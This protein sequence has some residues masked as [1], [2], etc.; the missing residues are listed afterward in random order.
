MQMATTVPNDSVS[1]MNSLSGAVEKRYQDA[2]RVAQSIIFFGDV[3]KGGGAIGGIV[4]AIGFIVA[5]GHET[6]KVVPI[7][8][9]VGVLVAGAGWATGTI[10]AAIGQMMQSVVDTAVNTS[11]LL[12]AFH[13]AKLLGLQPD[14]E[15]SALPSTGQSQAE[16]YSRDSAEWKN[17]SEQYSRM[18]DEQLETL[19]QTGLK[20]LTPIARQ[21]LREEL[22]RR[23]LTDC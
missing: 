14:D 13:K 23:G 19:A 5:F 15:D 12:F 7:G 22:R 8:V 9:L 3:I 1:F 18:T 11:P 21:V 4:V 17:L 20:D 10:V 6:A 2:F 16:P